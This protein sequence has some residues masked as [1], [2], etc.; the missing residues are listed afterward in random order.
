MSIRTYIGC[1]FSGKTSEIQRE[2]T[3]WKNI[4][5]NVIIIN[6]TDDNRYGNDNFVYSHDNNKVPCVKAKKLLELSSE[7]VGRNDVIIINEG[8]FFEDLIEFCKIWCEKHNKNIVVCGLDGDF[9]R[10]PFG[11]MNDLISLSDE[12]IKLKAFCKKCND[13]TQALFSKRTTSDTQSV[14]IGTDMYMPVCRKHYID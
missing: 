8:Q 11:Q 1:M 6:Y 13:G 5:K 7:E 3:R 2:Y 10:R 9:L 4:G 12:V 14:V